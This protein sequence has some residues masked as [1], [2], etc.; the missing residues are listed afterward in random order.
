M[1]ISPLC[2]STGWLNTIGMASDEGHHK[3]K[4]GAEKKCRAEKIFGADFFIF[5][6]KRG[7][8]FS[9]FYEKHLVPLKTKF[10]ES[11]FSIE[12]KKKSA[13]F[14]SAK[15]FSAPLFYCGEPPRM[16]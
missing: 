7:A 16:P 10:Q 2:M 6:E 12:Y 1:H 8:D 15:F 13:K 5:Y 3:K 4:S 11:R 14:F 9:V